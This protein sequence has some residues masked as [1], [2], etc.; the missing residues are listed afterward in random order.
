LVV[1]AYASVHEA[2]FITNDCPGNSIMNEAEGGTGSHRLQT[3][4][5]A[6]F[7][8]A[9]T[10]L[11]VSLEV[12][13]SFA[14]LLA[15]MQGFIA[16]SFAFAALIYIWSIHYRLFRRFP[17]DDNWSVLLNACLLCDRLH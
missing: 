12:P 3:F 15:D 10:L 11:V 2:R 8:I 16:F 13:K 17:L 7:A 5:D 6:V 4:S 1:A 14:A 9:C